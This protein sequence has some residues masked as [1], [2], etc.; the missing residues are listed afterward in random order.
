MKNITPPNRLQPK[1]PAS[2]SRVRCRPNGVNPL[3][4]GG[5]GRPRPRLAGLQPKA[6][7]RSP[8]QNPTK[9]NFAPTHKPT[10]CKKAA[11]LR[12]SAASSSVSA[13]QTS[14]PNPLA[15]RSPSRKPS[16][17]PNAQKAECSHRQ[18]APAK[19]GQRSPA[20]GLTAKA[21]WRWLL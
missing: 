21:R 17:A 3:P 12:L 16:P 5:Q 20:D 8:S 19:A 18:R 14:K 4:A 15:Q 10:Q 1:S 7:Q 9:K 13:A 2:R 11:L 6:Y